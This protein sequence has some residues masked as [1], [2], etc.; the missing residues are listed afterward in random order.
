MQEC[1]G[2][3]FT[4]G[5]LRELWL[6]IQAETERQVRSKGVFQAGHS[7]A[8]GQS[9]GGEAMLQVG[10]STARGQS[11]GGE[12]E[13]GV[14]RPMGQQPNILP[15]S[16]CQPRMPEGRVWVLLLAQAQPQQQRGQGESTRGQSMAREDGETVPGKRVQTEST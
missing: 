2:G 15:P 5:G 8:R 10:H 9:L 3:T 1:R 13:A 4:P 7:M 6:E 12:G 14:A 16:P 11:L